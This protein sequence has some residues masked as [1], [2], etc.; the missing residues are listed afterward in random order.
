MSII[1]IIELSV[2]D[3]SVEELKKYLKDA[4]PDTRVFEG[5]KGVQLYSNV[6]SPSDFV[7]H[8]K[9][10]SDEAYKKYFAWRLE[11]GA[12]DKLGSMCSNSLSPQIYNIIDG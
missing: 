11:T 2:K 6:K 12:V 7:L 10:A 4:L 3:D 8:E 5:C 9:W 1:V